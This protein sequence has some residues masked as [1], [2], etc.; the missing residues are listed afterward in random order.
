MKKETRER[1]C[2]TAYNWM[3]GR[4]YTLEGADIGEAFETH[5]NIP[6]DIQKLQEEFPFLR[7]KI[8][9]GYI[10]RGTRYGGYDGYNQETVW[11][12][13]YFRTGLTPKE[14]PLDW[15]K[16][17]ELLPLEK[18][19]IRLRRVMQANFDDVKRI[20]N[21]SPNS[22]K[23][24]LGVP[25]FFLTDYDVMSRTFENGIV[26]IGPASAYVW[27]EKTEHINDGRHWE[28]WMCWVKNHEYFPLAI[29]I[30]G[31]TENLDSLEKRLGLDRA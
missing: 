14:E 29:L 9:Q 6:L 16:Q 19:Q 12:D 7:K 15:R 22:Q 5:V 10:S 25:P 30:S 3:C 2:E 23:F 26:H 8:G 28:A 20:V 1:R 24:E 18:G 11:Y 31:S 17:L 27:E 4:F 13:E 21:E